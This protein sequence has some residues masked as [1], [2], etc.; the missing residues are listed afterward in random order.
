MAA[1]FE[2]EG[3]EVEN[4]VAEGRVSMSS[5]DEGQSA[6]AD[7]ANSLADVEAAMSSLRD[8]DQW[9]GGETAEV[10]ERL[11]C[12]REAALRAE[13]RAEFEQGAPVRTAARSGVAQVKTWSQA[14]V[15]FAAGPAHL[16]KQWQVPS[17]LGS[18]LIVLVQTVVVVGALAGA[19]LPPCEVSDQCAN[20]RYC[21]VGSGHQCKFCGSLETIDISNRT[22]VKETCFARLPRSPG[23]QPRIRSDALVSWC[24]TCVRAIDG[25]VDKLTSAELARDYVDAM[26]PFDWVTLICASVRSSMAAHYIAIRKQPSLRSA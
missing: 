23:E 20:G 12:A 18:A 2:V 6:G 25:T 15:N 13:I 22:T 10:V 19:F 14:T 7:A 5:K 1:V 4:P 11:L 9:G 16:Q 26:S 24:E 3:E 17:A 8:I 21:T